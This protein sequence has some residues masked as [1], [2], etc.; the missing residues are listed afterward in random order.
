MSNIKV[1]DKV[2]VVKIGK[3]V[4]ASLKLFDILT[5]SKCY[6]FANE[7]NAL[8]IN[9]SE[10]FIRDINTDIDFSDC[11][12][13]TEKCEEPKDELEDEPN[14]KLKNTYNEYKS[15]ISGIT[16]KEENIDWRKISTIPGIT[17]KGDLSKKPHPRA[18]N[19]DFNMEIAK[20]FRFG[21]LKHGVD[22]FRTMTHEA[23]G[24]LID[25]LDRHLN[26]YLRGETH[27]DDS[28]LHHLAHAAANLH[29]L[30]RLIKRHGDAKVL[31]VIS[32]GDIK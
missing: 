8:D 6:N 11:T 28:K 17:G 3:D 32:G 13:I 9:G 30:Y 2:K 29:M 1:G 15:T 23:S 16:G 22:N 21:Q 26:A 18:L 14:D 10:W 31:E 19:P 4:H 12:I 24:E 5:I 25:A 27:A 20:V 7:F